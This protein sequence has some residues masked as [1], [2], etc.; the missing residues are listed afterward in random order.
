MEETVSID[1]QSWRVYRPKIST[2]A[3][4]QTRSSMPSRNSTVEPREETSLV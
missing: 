4:C 1:K 2:G 3:A